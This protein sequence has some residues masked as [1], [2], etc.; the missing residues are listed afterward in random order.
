V[1]KNDLVIKISEKMDLRQVDVKKVVQMT[2]DGIMECL[3]EE[4]R[5]ELRNF[6]VFEVRERKARKAINP[7]T[8]GVVHVPA[9]KVVT[10]KTG[11]EMGELI[12]KRR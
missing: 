3:A 5:I 4:G 6:G 8:G 9:K 7:R 1:T 2:L 11:K 10:F 12:R